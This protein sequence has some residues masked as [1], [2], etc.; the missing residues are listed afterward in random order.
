MDSLVD[1]MAKTHEAFPSLREQ[2]SAHVQDERDLASAENE[3]D[4]ACVSAWDEHNPPLIQVPLRD[5]RASS[6][7]SQERQ[8]TMIVQDEP[9]TVQE[10]AE[11]AYHPNLWRSNSPISNASALQAQP[12]LASQKLNSED[13]AVLYCYEFVNCLNLGVSACSQ[14]PSW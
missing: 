10:T 13:Y 1:Y 7:P 6:M 11:R 5:E 4:S 12:R 2:S 3:Q 8:N 9:R 14:T